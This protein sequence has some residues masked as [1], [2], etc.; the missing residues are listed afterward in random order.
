MKGKFFEK[1]KKLF[2]EIKID[3]KL[4]VFRKENGYWGF[5]EKNPNMIN[6][7]EEASLERYANKKIT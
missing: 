7:T 4:Y 5:S 1:V 6:I 2:T 3:G